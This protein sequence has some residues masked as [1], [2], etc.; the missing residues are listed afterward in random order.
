MEC[1][2]STRTISDHFIFIFLYREQYVCMEDVDRGAS[3][4][5]LG[6]YWCRLLISHLRVNGGIRDCGTST[7]GR[8]LMSIQR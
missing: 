4:G 1:F 5:A 8:D 6:G 2:G 7:A 3:L